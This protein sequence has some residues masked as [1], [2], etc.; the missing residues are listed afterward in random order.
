MSTKLKMFRGDDYSFTAIVYDT[1]GE[2]E[3]LTNFSLLFTIK[4][5]KSN[6]ANVFQ[7]SSTSSTEIS[8]SSTVTG[9]YTVYIDSADTN[10]LTPDID[11]WY[12]VQITNT[13]N[14]KKYTTMVGNF[15]IES[16]ITR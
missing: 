10:D 8:K 12:D 1:E 6:T 3:D 16:D 9:E 2:A 5:E 15:A 11:Y 14:S 4:E 13:T 7:K